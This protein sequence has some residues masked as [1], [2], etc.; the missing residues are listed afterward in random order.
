MTHENAIKTAKAIA[1]RTGRHAYVVHEPMA[2][3][4]AETGFHVSDVCGVNA[5]FP[6]ARRIA[7]VH[8]DTR[9]EVVGALEAA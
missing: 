1:A 5:L 8:P 9:V 4:T 2:G 3:E 6:R 7:S